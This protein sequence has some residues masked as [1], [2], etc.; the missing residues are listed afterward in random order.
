MECDMRWMGA[1]EIELLCLLVGLE[2]CDKC[3]GG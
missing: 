3:L 1:E 2:L